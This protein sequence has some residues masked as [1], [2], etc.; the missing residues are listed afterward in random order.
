[1]GNGGDFQL[2]IGLAGGLVLKYPILGVNAA[3][4]TP[5]LLILAPKLNH[6]RSSAQQH[7]SYRKRQVTARLVAS[8]HVAHESM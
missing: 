7:P 8:L 5:D 2:K 1:M 6:Q 3:L 4:D